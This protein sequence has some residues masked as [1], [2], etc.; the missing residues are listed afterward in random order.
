MRP[1]CPTS[2]SFESERENSIRV[3]PQCPASSSIESEREN[4]IRVR[5]QCPASRLAK[6]PAITQPVVASVSALTPLES[7]FKCSVS[8]SLVGCSNGVD[9]QHLY[10]SVGSQPSHLSL[11]S[12]E[13][14][15]LDQVHFSALVNPLGVGLDTYE[16][17]SRLPSC[18][19]SKPCGSCLPVATDLRGMLWRDLLNVHY[20]RK[21]SPSE[22]SK[23]LWRPM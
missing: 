15:H 13:G 12:F 2:S 9:L 21:K 3:R 7:L 20:R 4:S 22:T 18:Y 19:F 1:L 16:V 10:D 8:D 17:Y 5:P 14:E 11:A 23:S 6:G